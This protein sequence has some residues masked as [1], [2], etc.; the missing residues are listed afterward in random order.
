MSDVQTSLS[1]EERELLDEAR[2]VRENAYAP[3]SEFKVGAAVRCADGRIF[4]GCN[5]EN[6]SYGMTICAERSALVQ[7]VAA[8]CRTFSAIAV[9]YDKDGQPASPC[10]ACRQFMCEFRPDFAVLLGTADPAGPVV[11]TSVDALIPGA[12]RF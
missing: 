8:G 12:F 3:Y 11:K 7:A 2:R 5:V 9:V 6:S 1:P 10:G 4:A